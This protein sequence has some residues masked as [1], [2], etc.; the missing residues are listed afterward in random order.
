M[1]SEELKSRFKSFAIRIIRLVDCLPSTTS[2]KV[3]GNQIIRS[4][5]SPGAN[6][7]AACVAKSDKDFVNKLKIVEE[8]LDETLY[9]L[10]LIT[11]TELLKPKLLVEL[12]KEANEL[13]LITRS[14]ILTKKKKMQS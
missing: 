3:L 10:D 6:Y 9:W 11:E 5:T 2:G 14:S 4:G 12:R 8:E 13:L 7:R 1:T